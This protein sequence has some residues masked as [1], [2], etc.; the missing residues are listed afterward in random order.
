M[1]ER[2]GTKGHPKELAAL[3]MEFDKML[4]R[5]GDSFE[6]LTL[7][8]ADAAHEFRTPLNSLMMATSLTLARERTAE[9]YRHAL[10][11]NLEEFERLKG[12]VDKLLFLARAENAETILNKTCLDAAKITGDVLD[13]F[14][15]LAEERG[16]TLDCEGEGIVC[17]DETLLRQALA[18]LLSN[19]L[20]HTPSGGHVRVRIQASEAGCAISVS[21]TGPGIPE[22][23]WPKLFDR[24]YRVDAARSSEGD[25][26]AGL[27]LAIVKTIMGMHHGDVTVSSGN[28]SGSCFQL[29]FPKRKDEETGRSES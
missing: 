14:S 5:L 21:D 25:A 29:V 27:G 24:F 28:P 11:G 1:N 23:H 15:A 20:R 18:N 13:F 26:G 10:A 22:S 17:A 2:L 4:D 9:E 7:F 16:V 6:R 3:A 19:A 12:M 8:T